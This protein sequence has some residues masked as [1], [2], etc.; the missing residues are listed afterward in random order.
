MDGY[1]FVET[2]KGNPETASLPIIMLTART[3]IETKLKA[4]RLGIDDYM[5]KPFEKEE[6]LA[7]IENLI[8]HS[9]IRKESALEESAVTDLDV[10][11][12]AQQSW[13]DTLEKYILNRV[14]DSSLTVP[15]IA[16]AF[17]LSESSLLR[18]TKQLLGLSP[19]KYLQEVRLDYARKLLEAG[20][21]NSI[22]ELAKNTGFKDTSTFSRNYKKRFGK[23]PSDY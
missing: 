14:N 13:L 2:V 5:T 7:R 4:L 8:Q 23:S 3:E 6:L 15:D 16:S 17:A 10:L 22:K 19:I 21:I 18:K 12:E 11:D 20:E 9:S 1:A